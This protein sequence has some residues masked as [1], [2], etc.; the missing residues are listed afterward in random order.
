MWLTQ[1][2]DEINYLGIVIAMLLETYLPVVQSEI[3][4][5]FSGSAAARGELSIWL[6]VLMGALGSEL[7][8]ISLFMIARKF[9][10]E[11]LI[12][13]V[14]RYGSW[15]GYQKAEFE[16]ADQ[17]LEKHQRATVFFGR[18]VPGVRSFVA[19][20]AGLHQMKIIEFA[21]L[22]LFG[23]VIWVASL[24]WLGYYLSNQY[25]VVSRYS[26]YITYAL[27]AFVCGFILYRLIKVRFFNR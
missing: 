9:D 11:K 17:W 6:V 15:L 18:F 19:I 4:M 23:T 22:N 5:T 2:I 13:F 8:A 20:P 21:L 10:R 16:R 12:H 7:G 25:Q 24:A 26:S 1:F 3:V 27:I 14:S